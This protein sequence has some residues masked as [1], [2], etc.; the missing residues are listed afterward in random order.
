M[1]LGRLMLVLLGFLEFQGSPG[2]SLDLQLY[3]IA[4]S[5]IL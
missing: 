5:G 2:M 4:H 1:A 3:V